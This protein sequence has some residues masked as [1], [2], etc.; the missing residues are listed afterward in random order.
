MR[1]GLVALASLASLA[2]LGG[3]K[4]DE[5]ADWLD[6]STLLELGGE[7]GNA[8]GATWSGSYV[9]EPSTASCDCPSVM[10]A[11]TSVDLCELVE[12]AAPT[13]ELTHADGFLIAPFGAG[14]LSGPV[15]TDGGFALASVQD[16]STLAGAARLL[17]RIDGT[18]EL[19]APGALL[20]AEAGQRLVGELGGESIDCRWL[21]EVS[22]TRTD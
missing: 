3:C 12:V 2:W 22:G 4:P 21:G 8:S 20:H 17:A 9:L 15:D 1:L 6:E 16:I 14:M 7:Q 18:L 11:D 5:P 19:A 13:L 10:L